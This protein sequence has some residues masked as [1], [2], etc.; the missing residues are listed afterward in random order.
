MLHLSFA[1]PRNERRRRH[2]DGARL[3]RLASGVAAALFVALALLLT[4][5]CAGDGANGGDAP[6]VG[7]QP[8]PE[9]G[10]DTSGRAASQSLE[11]YFEELRGAFG[12]FQEA[13]ISS[14]QPDDAAVLTDPEG[15]LE[16]IQG[17]LVGLEDAVSVFVNE[18]EALA[19]PSEV[20]DAH[21]AFLVTLRSD[22]DAII[23]LAAE[24]Q[25]AGSV[26]EVTAAL[27]ARSY[28]LAQSR[29]PCRRLQEIA[30]EHDIDVELPCEA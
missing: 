17:T 23:E 9:D 10:S 16:F 27:Q 29:E 7:S 20:V 14:A 18:V 24:V 13:V 2:S 5:A 19:P 6:T 15:F 22:H 1:P 21:E 25:E 28:T 8:S 12:R 4:L 26:E 11:Q 30:L 3:A